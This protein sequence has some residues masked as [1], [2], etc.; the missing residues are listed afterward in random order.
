MPLDEET[1]TESCFFRSSARS[2]DVVNSHGFPTRIT[3]YKLPVKDIQRES[4]RSFGLHHLAEAK[5]SSHSPNRGNKQ[6]SLP[7]LH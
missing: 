7:A 6:L 3:F 4:W 1:G 5:V 2:D